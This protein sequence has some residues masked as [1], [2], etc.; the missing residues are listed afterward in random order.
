M[1]THFSH[2]HQHHRHSLTWSNETLRAVL[3]N[4]VTNLVAHFGERCYSWDVVNEA[5]SSDA[6]PPPPAPGRPTCSWYD[7]IG[8]EYFFLT[9]QKPPPKPWHSSETAGSRST[10]P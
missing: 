10:S 5:L 1:L 7:T 8:P 3:V 2:D 6:P 4:H 9:L